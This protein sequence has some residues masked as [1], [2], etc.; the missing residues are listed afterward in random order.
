MPLIFA[1]CTDKSVSGVV[2]CSAIKEIASTCLRFLS[3]DPNVKGDEKDEKFSSILENLSHKDTTQELRTLSA[4]LLKRDLSAFADLGERL[5]DPGS[6]T[7]HQFIEIILPTFH[8]VFLGRDSSEDEGVVMRSPSGRRCKK[9]RVVGVSEDSAIDS[10]E[11]KLMFCK[12]AIKLILTGV[13][14]RSETV[15]SDGS[16]EMEQEEAA[17]QENQA[18]GKDEEEDEIGGGGE[19]LKYSDGA[20]ELLRRLHQVLAFHE[21]VVLVSSLND[22]SSGRKAGDLQRLNKPL[23]IKLLPSSFGGACSTTAQDS[24]L[25]VLAEPLVPIRDLQLHILRTCSNWD[26]PY[27]D[28]CTQ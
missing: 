6:V 22:D 4:R 15:S 26:Q 9:A 24:P 8:T 23:D 10:P 20:Q 25:H 12:Q 11:D 27:I 28:F 19:P 2:K 7:I 16:E 1:D 5:L 21:R 17:S 14:E 3:E 13:D 18:D